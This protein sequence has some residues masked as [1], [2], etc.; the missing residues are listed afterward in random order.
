MC[1][2]TN[3]PTATSTEACINQYGE[4]K[5]ALHQETDS[6]DSDS[7]TDSF[8]SSSSNASIEISN[9]INSESNTIASD[10][11][12]QRPKK[13]VQFKDIET[14]KYDRTLGDNPSVTDGCPIA[15]D[16]TYTSLPAV[17]ID[18]YEMHRLPRRTRRHLALTPITRR[19]SM[20]YHFGYSHEEIDKC[21]EAVKKTKH[22]RCV[23]K[24]LSKNKEKTQEV[25]QT[26]TRRMKRTF[27][28]AKIYWD[29][30]NVQASRGNQHL[31]G[32][33]LVR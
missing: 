16:W 33:L 29:Q 27:S 15:L 5:H 6:D 3:K 18:E 13:S 31:K 24:K 4:M 9:E 1:Q 19:N 26:V 2:Q 8:S 12:R 23:T 20:Y 25:L 28:R 30:P 10:N 21:A 11:N 32:L 7:D 22:Q 14:R 17:S